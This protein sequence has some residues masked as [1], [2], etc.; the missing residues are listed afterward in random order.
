MLML[1]F[2]KATSVI[3]Y[4]KQYEKYLNVLKYRKIETTKTNQL[5][6]IRLD[7]FFKVNPVTRAIVKSSLFNA[8]KAEMSNT[9]KVLATTQD[10]LKVEFMVQLPLQYMQSLLNDFS[11]DEIGV[12]Y[13]STMSNILSNGIGKLNFITYDN[14]GTEDEEKIKARETRLTGYRTRI[15]ECLSIALNTIQALITSD[16]DADSNSIFALLP[17]LYRANAL[18]TID[19]QYEKEYL[20]YSGNPEVASMLKDMVDMANQVVSNINNSIGM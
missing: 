14:E 7:G 10:T 2:P 16:T 5:Y 18:V 20:E 1:G 9:L 15:K 13:E 8:N 6:N 3:K 12:Q 17:V 4:N 19:L 11:T